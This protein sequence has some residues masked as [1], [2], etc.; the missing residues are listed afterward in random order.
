MPTPSCTR[1]GVN[2]C[3]AVSSL[4]EQLYAFSISPSNEKQM[5]L[6]IRCITLEVWDGEV[7]IIIALPYR[8]S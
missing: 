1:F 6:A 7:T 5:F 2:K 8:P 4:M 3:V